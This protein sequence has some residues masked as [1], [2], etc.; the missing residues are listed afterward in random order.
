MEIAMGSFSIREYTDKMRSVDSKKC[1]PFDGHTDGGEKGRSLPPISSRK[2]RWWFDELQRQRSA[3]KK[4][5]E[6]DDRVEVEKNGNKKVIRGSISESMVKTPPVEPTVNENSGAVAG[7]E[8]DGRLVR[9]AARGKQRAPKKRSIAELFAVAPLVETF[10]DDANGSDGR[11]EP[12]EDGEDGGERDQEVEVRDLGVVVKGGGEYLEP[13]RKRKVLGLKDDCKKM[14]KVGKKI[15]EKIKKKSKNNKLRVEICAAEK[16]KIGKSKMPSPVAIPRILQ[17]KLH[18]KQF[19]RIRRNL[20]DRQKKTITAKTL[21]KKRNFNLNRTSR[22]ISRNQKEVTRALPLRSIL[23]NRKGGTSVKKDKTIGDAQGRN[24]I[25]LYCESAKHVSFSGKDD[26]LGLNK[27]HSPMELPHLQNL[28]KIF[29]DILA[30]SSAMDNLSKVD[31]CPTP[32]EGAQVVNSSDTDLATSVEGT[33]GTLSEEKQLSDSCGHCNPWSFTDP[34]KG[35]SPETKGTPLCESVDLNYAVQDCSE[36]SCFRLDCSTMSHT[37]AYSGNA[38]DLNP[39]R[40]AKSNCVAETHGEQSAQMTADDIRNQHSPIEKCVPSSKSRSSLTLTGNPGLQHST[41]SMEKGLEANKGQHPPCVD[42][43]DFCSQQ[44]RFQ[45]VRHHSPERLMSSIS[46]SVGSKEFGESKI[47]SDLMSR[48]RDKRIDEDFISLPL[49]SQG[50]LMQLRSNTKS[51]Y[52]DFYEKQDSVR[53]SVC[54]VP[55]PNYVEPN[56]SHVKLK[57]KFICASL[58]Q[59]NRSNWSLDGY[60]PASKVA[61]SGLGFTDLQ[62][63]VRMEMQNHKDFE[64]STH[65]DPNEMEVSC[66]ACRE[67]NK[68]EHYVDRVNFHAEMK[69]D[70]KFQPATQPTMRLMGQNVA[71]GRSNEECLGFNDGKTWTE[72]ELIAQNCPSI[73]VSDKPFLQRWFPGESVE[74]AESV[75]STENFF[76]SLEVPSSFY[77][78]PATEFRSNPMHLDFQPQWSLGSEIS[79]AIESHGYDVDLFGHSVPQ[80]LLK[81]T[82]SA[83]VNCN[84]GTQHVK[85]EHQQPVLGSYPQNVNRHMLLNPACPDQ[86]S[87]SFS[88]TPIAHSPTLPHWLLNA[89]QQKKLQQS[90]CPYSAPLSAHQPSVIHGNNVFTFSSPY[91]TPAI[92]FPFYGSNTSQTYSLPGPAPVVH[93]L[94]ISALGANKSHPAVNTS[95]R[96]KKNKNVRKFQF[97]NVKGLDCTNRTIKRPADKGDASMNSAKKVNLNLQEDS[98]VQKDT[99]RREQRHG[100]KKCS[101]GSSEIN[102]CGSKITDVG[103]PALGNE[104]NLVV[105]SGPDASNFYPQEST[106]FVKLS[107]GAKHI[108][109]PCQNMDQDKYRPVHSTIRFAVGTSSDR[110][111]GSQNKGSKVYGF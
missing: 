80:H 37:D 22:L 95:Y 63:F 88:R 97:A 91:P 73:T 27:R 99:G 58:Y 103:L 72:K 82:Y 94:A 56:C 84:S 64:Q 77:P 52:S 85:R 86:D 57:G 81:K 68:T 45:P 41:S 23:K 2:F 90:S 4:P 107:A 14:G 92:S 53:N 67:C 70:K 102:A 61:T 75:S 47:T 24:F 79:P 9:V 100:N 76:K 48:C 43:I 3:G 28:C 17:N 1:W 19:R 78:M 26:I 10:E 30:A 101:I 96:S 13:P 93:H 106:G 105:A 87:W 83:V 60:Y 46:S 32:T 16:E 29:S 89:T 110:K 15:K 71:V 111:Q 55:L 65:C 104:D 109:N 6:V 42:S 34:R 39:I 18:N 59:K 7:V 25:K 74:N 8:E 69:L 35:K 49:N 36:L 62:G 51:A 12:E 11:E 66:C 33:N 50:E 31:K 108:L 44:P 5:E 38:E 40:K 20:I 54:N 98:T 21:P